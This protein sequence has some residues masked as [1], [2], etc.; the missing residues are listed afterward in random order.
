MALGALQGV[1]EV[2]PISSSGHLTLV[3]ALLGWRYAELDANLRKAFEV[4]VH[5]GSAIALAGTLR[6]DLEVLAREH[7]ARE[8]LGAA[9]ALAPPALVGM[10][11]ERRFD[12][13]LARP[14]SIAAVQVVAGAALALADCRPATRRYG[15]ARSLDHL[16]L[17]LAQ[18][19]ALVPG[20]SRNGS[21]LT[22]ARLRRFNRPSAT[23]LSRHA[24]LPVVAGAAVYKGARQAHEG[25]PRELRRPFAAGFA[26][27]LLSTLA[28]RPLLARMV[29][30]RTYAPLGL[31]R[32]ALGAVG[33]VG[34]GANRGSA[35]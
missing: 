15:A 13:R 20:V 1:A 18:A 31:Y 27:A 32:A 35:A 21:T 25:L 3:P 24:A 28:S 34:V 4:A 12:E 5:A 14:R 29:H 23:R 11:L 33:L 19:A 7:D 22:G 16:V 8:A 26:A 6:F 17:G 30:A 10:A 9:L 2:L